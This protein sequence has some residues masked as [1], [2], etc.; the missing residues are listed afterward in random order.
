MKIIILLI[1]LFAVSDVSYALNEKKGVE[2]IIGG[3]QYASIGQYRL[4]QFK[5]SIEEHLKNYKGADLD[6]YINNLE[7][8]Y[9]K[10]KRKDVSKVEIRAIFDDLRSRRAMI[11]E[12]ATTDSLIAEMEEILKNENKGSRISRNIKIDP[13]KVK[14]IEIK[15][16]TQDPKNL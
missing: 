3:E 13:E 15:P 16:Q 9:L 12:V 14:T 2:V 10:R 8:Q 1:V 7:K 6:E 11:E 5:A 4:N